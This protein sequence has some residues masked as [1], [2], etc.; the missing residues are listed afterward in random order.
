MTG[1]VRQIPVPGTDK[2]IAY[3]G[4]KR[5]G[6]GRAVLD[7]SHAIAVGAYAY[8]LNRLDAQG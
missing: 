1:D 4:L 6:I 2:T 8:A 7:T 5:I 3:D